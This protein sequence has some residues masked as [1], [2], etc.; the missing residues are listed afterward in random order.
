MILSH[1]QKFAEKCMVTKVEK[2][3][4]KLENAA[5][6]CIWLGYANSHAFGT[7]CMLNPK[8]RCCLHEKVLF[9]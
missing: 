8:T 7:Y 1:L 9:P 4:A 3:K 6:P 2:L 5:I